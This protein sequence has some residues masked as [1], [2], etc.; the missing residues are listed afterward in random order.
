MFTSSTNSKKQTTQTEEQILPPSYTLISADLSLKRPGFCKLSITLQN[1]T[2]HINN[3]EL[4]SVDNKTKTKARGMI[5]LEIQQALIDFSA[6][7]LPV[8]FVRERSVNNC[9][10]KMA[11]S[12]TMARIGVSEVIGIADLV[13]W[14]HSHSE[15]EE[16][17]PVT[18]KKLITGSGKSEKQD[19]ANAL[20]CYL[21]KLDYKNDDESDAAAVA[22]AWLI[23]HKQISQITQED[24]KDES[25]KSTL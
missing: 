15:W 16:I 21:G 5:L 9:G 4:M 17:F 18:I 12:G 24:A 19:V 3:V 1:G 20:N 25:N 11:R 14:T 6:S 22:V 13:A 23:N 7:D 8:F 2:A 10:G